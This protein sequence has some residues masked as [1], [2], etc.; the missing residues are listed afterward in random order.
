MVSL[1]DEC[2][3]LFVL[4]V[5]LGAA[6]TQPEDVHAGEPHATRVCGIACGGV[7]RARHGTDCA[8]GSS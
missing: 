5:R 3:Q 8:T 4:G 1:A 6:H 7:S 2:A